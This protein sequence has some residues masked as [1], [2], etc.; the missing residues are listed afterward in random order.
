M[1]QILSLDHLSL[2]RMVAVRVPPSDCFLPNGTLLPVI[3]LLKINGKRSWFISLIGKI[4]SIKPEASS[5]FSY[6]GLNDTGV[7]KNQFS[8]LKLSDSSKN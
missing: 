4:S 3:C 7:I 5:V 6:V 8:K 2:G 1:L